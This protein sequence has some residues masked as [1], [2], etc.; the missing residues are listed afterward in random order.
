[1]DIILEL[2]HKNVKGK[3]PIL[4]EYHEKHSGKEGY[5]LEKQFGIQHS[6]KNL[7]DIFGYELKKFSKN[8]I[9]LG[10]FGAN[11][12]LF[13]KQK[14]YLCFLNKWSED[15]Q[16]SRDKFIQT[17]G[18]FNEMKNRYSWSGKCVPTYNVWNDNGQIL[19]INETNDII[20]YYSFS[21]DKRDVKYAFPNYLHEDNVAIVVW[22]MNKLKSFVD[23][24]FNRRGFFICEKI[25][26]VYQTISFGLPFNFE[27][28]INK[29]K[30]GQ[31]IFDSG[32]YTGNIRNYSQFRG[33]HSFWFDL[34]TEIHF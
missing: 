18:N 20:I 19:T 11:E 34:I 28:F 13:S 30:C 10:D 1:M 29:I 27:Y 31:I 8:K 22:K 6:S 26:D 2:F 24:K 3:S 25:K 33:N 23:N 5:W 16:M 9:T 21:K 15:V 12:Y 7:P 14:D 17:F 32:M 4:D